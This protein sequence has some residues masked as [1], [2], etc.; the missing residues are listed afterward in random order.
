MLADNQEK[1][2]P[3]KIITYRM[4]LL[5]HTSMSPTR[6]CTLLKEFHELIEDQLVELMKD[7]NQTT[8]ELDPC[9]CKLVYKCMDVLKG[10]LTKMVRTD[11]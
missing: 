3:K 7:M 2:L 1:K 5:T 9:S 8:C 10:T 6:S 11:N 4:N